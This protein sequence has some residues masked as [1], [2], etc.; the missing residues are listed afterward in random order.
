MT[1]P[2]CGRTS[3]APSALAGNVVAAGRGNAGYERYQGTILHELGHAYDTQAKLSS[4]PEFRS[5]QQR[6]GRLMD[7]YYA[8]AGDAGPQE[9]FADLARA[10][11]TGGTAMVKQQFGSAAAAWMTVNVP[12]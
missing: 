10:Y 12:R 11:W 9:Y 8:Q 1:R 2:S 5:L 3:A 7:P 6:V 4:T